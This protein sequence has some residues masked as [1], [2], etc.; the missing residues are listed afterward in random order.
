M[1][2]NIIRYQKCSQKQSTDSLVMCRSWTLLGCIIIIRVVL[3]SYKMSLRDYTFGIN[4]INNS[5]YPA[6]SL[7]VVQIHNHPSLLSGASLE[8]SLP[9]S[10]VHKSLREPA[11]KR[12]FIIM[13]STHFCF[14][15]SN[16]VFILVLGYVMST[17]HD[18][19]HNATLFQ[20]EYIPTHL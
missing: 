8:G 15:S 1:L 14:K 20:A 7:V 12:P 5:C 6:A 10:D 3:L 2:L 13:S 4:C 16:Y 11:R 19:F 9:L 17:Q 18:R